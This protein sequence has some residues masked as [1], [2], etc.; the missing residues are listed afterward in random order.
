VNGKVVLAGGTGTLERRLADGL[1]TRGHDVVVLT[2]NPDQHAGH[3]HV[4]WNGVDVG[5]WRNE[6]RGAALVNLAGA[7][8]DRRATPANVELLT[9]SRVDPTSALVRA[10]SML[11]EPP[12]VWVQMS[13]LAIY[14]DRGDEVLDESSAPATEPPQMAGVARA[15]EAAAAGAA[16]ERQ[17]VLRTGIV[18][19]RGAPA[20]A[21]LTTIV[22]RGLGGRV[23]TGRQWVS[24]LHVDDFLAIVR[25][26]LA[27]GTFDGLVHATSPNPI[28]NVELMATLRRLLHRPW[29]PPTPGPLVHVGAFLMRT[30]PALAL[31]GRR[32]IPRRLTE[33]GFQFAYPQLDEALAAV[34][35]R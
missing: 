24:W 21:R 6:L 22:R 28:R 12:T 7:L 13:T 27:D 26:V 15:W 1:A 8:V 31:T 17:P 29:S 11:D 30:D 33:T 16:A 19:D 23:G 25:A 10:A 35:D 2:R 20:V 3:R 34:L 18:F 14:G 5:P 9:K 4:A 32:A